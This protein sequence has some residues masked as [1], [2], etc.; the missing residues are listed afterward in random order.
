[1][2]GPLLVVTTLVAGLAIAACGPRKKPA[3]YVPPA[4]TPLA[5]PTPTPT[6]TVT[7]P[8]ATP[9]NPFGLPTLFPLPS[10]LPTLPFPIPGIPTA[11]S[12]GSGTSF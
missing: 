3:A 10:T 9:T 4:P 5:S 1:M 7:P 11:T 8:S 12:T 2:R 6:Q